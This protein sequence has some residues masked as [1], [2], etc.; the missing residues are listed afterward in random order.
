M[1]VKNICTN[2]CE[3]YA[4]SFDIVGLMPC[5]HRE[6]STFSMKGKFFISEMTY[7]CNRFIL[8][9]CRPTLDSEV[10]HLLCLLLNTRILLRSGESKVMTSVFQSARK[11]STAFFTSTF[12]L[13]DYSLIMQISQCPR[14]IAITAK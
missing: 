1:I 4:N 7:L 13:P 10:F 6:E 8:H 3:I 9:P 5:L 12:C 11:F 2:D 14:L